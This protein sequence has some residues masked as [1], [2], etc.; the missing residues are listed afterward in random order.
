MKKYVVTMNI[1]VW[2]HNAV[3]AAYLFAEQFPQHKYDT[4]QP[5]ESLV[6]TGANREIMLEYQPASF[7]ARD[8]LK[9]LRDKYSM[10]EN[11]KQQR[12]FQLCEQGLTLLDEVD[13]IT[14]QKKNRRG[15]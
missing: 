8:H 6:E 1:E 13:D 14:A 11:A 9:R 5:V 4:I 10:P 3:H 2:A 7:T 12:V 15:L